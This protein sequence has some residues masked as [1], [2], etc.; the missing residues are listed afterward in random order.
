[1]LD[2]AGG[3]GKWIAGDELESIVDGETAH[4]TILS[5]T[6]ELASDLVSTQAIEVTT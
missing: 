2:G 4:C 3:I 6:N 1:M 5:G